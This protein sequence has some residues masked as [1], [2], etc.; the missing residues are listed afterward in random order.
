MILKNDRELQPSVENLLKVVKSNML[1][2]LMGPRQTTTRWPR[3]VSMLLKSPNGE[4]SLT[5]RFFNKI[6]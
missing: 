1:C 5:L 6:R 4:I 3:P 2:W